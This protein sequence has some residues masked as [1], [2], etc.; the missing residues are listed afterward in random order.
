ML[1]E[2]HGHLYT[3]KLELQQKPK[4]I[5]NPMAGSAP[6]IPYFETHGHKAYLNDILPIHYHINKVKL[7]QCRNLFFEYGFEWFRE[8]LL[9]YFAPLDVKGRAVS[10][11][12]INDLILKDFINSWKHANKEEENISTILK[13]LILLSLKP[14][15]SFTNSTNPTWIKQGG[16]TSNRPIQEVVDE[17]IG[18]LESY[19]NSYPLFKK[20]GRCIIAIEDVM[21]LQMEEKVDL[22][23][24]SPPYCNRLDYMRIYS[25]EHSFLSNV[26]HPIIDSN[27][28]LLCYL[29]EN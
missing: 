23:F 24:T 16:L 4:V 27:L 17:K 28:I 15:S 22:I 6:L 25:P 1:W 29:I 2:I 19:Y 3:L 21:D 20:E 8:K 11:E 26:G 13:A 5:L 14:F 9:E 7:F 12:W 10:A 18:L